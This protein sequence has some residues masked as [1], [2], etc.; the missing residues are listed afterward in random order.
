MM[1]L[2]IATKNQHKVKEFERILNPFGIEV[3]S[4]TDAGIHIDVEETADSFEGNARLKARAVFEKTG[5]PTIA[6]DS[7]LEV[8]ALNGAP[9]IY[10]ARYGGEACKTDQDRCQKLLHEMKDIPDEH[11]TA[12]FV[13]CVYLILSKTQEYSFIGTCKG[14]IGYE[15]LGDNGF[16]YDPI[17]M[18]GDLS[19]GQLSDSQK[20]FISH[21]GN[22]LMQLEIKLK[23]IFNEGNI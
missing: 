3:I 7:G 10:S 8:F 21:R 12:Q 6:D 19:F 18:V 5:L 22:A 13:C 23:E 2:I 11:R 15:P 14:K 16:G 17:F 9:G 20:D 4:Q 1:K